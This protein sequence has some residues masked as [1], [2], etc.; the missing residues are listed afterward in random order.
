MSQSPSEARTTQ[1]LG[2]VKGA[3]LLLLSL[4]LLAL[5]YL[6]SFS[7]FLADDYCTRATLLD[8]G[9][10][11]SQANWYLNWSG[12]FSFTF[13]MNLT[14][15]LGPSFTPIMVWITVLLWLGV[16]TVTL[17]AMLRAISGATSWGISL[18]LGSLILGATVNGAPNLYQ[19]LL[20]HT[21]VVTYVV[22][23]I[24]G[25]AYLGWLARL[26]FSE[27]SK[28]SYSWVWALSLS[29]TFI[30]GGFSETYVSMQTAGL[31][32]LS[33]ASYVPRWRRNLSPIRN[34]VLAGLAGSLLSMLVI[35]VSP[36]SQ[37]RLSLM[38]DPGSLLSVVG[39]SVRNT[40][41]FVTK[42]IIGAPITSLL[43]ILLPIYVA[44]F[45]RPASK[46]VSASSQQTSGSTTDLIIVIPATTLLLIF[47]SIFPS[48]LA[49]SAYPAERAL[50]VT[51][52]AL[53]F[54]MV[55]WGFTIGHVGRESI[56]RWVRARHRGL[57][58]LAALV[59][60]LTLISAFASTQRIVA[61]LPDAREFSQDWD[62]RDAS[63]REAKAAGFR[64][65]D[66]ASLSHLGGL[67]EIGYDPSV[68]INICV[69]G[70]YGLESVVAK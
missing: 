67:E 9:F 41:A 2:V 54:S 56:R 35:G 52:Y 4:P 68:W 6:G 39:W 34:V 48:V 25:T 64:E 19:S 33:I 40:F 27:S 14:Q 21:G 57:V 12:R 31:L 37:A 60:T 23:L 65:L 3:L 18:L 7:R 38:P 49:T 58:W 16:L 17:K 15:L 24:L 29:W 59:L 26:L 1:W 32:A 28:G 11:G 55:L 42:A 61:W 47:A 36:G 69:A 63:I 51:Q 44:A 45:L 10:F 43:A 13:L 30:A 53:I 50:V 66:I 46:G 62:R 5:L 22:P 20:W 70:S 8:L